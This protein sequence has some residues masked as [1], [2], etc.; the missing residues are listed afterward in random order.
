MREET[1]SPELWG[2]AGYSAT[3]SDSNLMERGER[4]E[5]GRKGGIERGG[6]EGRER[7]KKQRRGKRGRKR[8]K[9]RQSKPPVAGRFRTPTSQKSSLI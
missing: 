7:E 2:E 1:T 4:K 3:S 9:G 5:E 6:K 8:R